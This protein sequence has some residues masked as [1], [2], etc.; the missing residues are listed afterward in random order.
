MR[1]RGS[2][3]QTWWPRSGSGVYSECA[4]SGRFRQGTD[5]TPFSLKEVCSG[6]FRVGQTGAA[7]TL[8]VRGGGGL[9]QRVSEAEVVRVRSRCTGKATRLPLLRV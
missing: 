5:I 1:S 9:E 4:G 7:A 3:D 6:R 8:R 2:P